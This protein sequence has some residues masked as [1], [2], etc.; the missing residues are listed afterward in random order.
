M[1]GRV[2]SRPGQGLRRSW[3]DNHTYKERSLGSQ[4]TQRFILHIPGYPTKVPCR[5]QRGGSKSLFEDSFQKQSHIAN[6][7]ANGISQ[8]G[9]AGLANANNR[10]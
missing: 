1:V 5:R 3:L 4:E 6:S 2:R 10:K 9:R 8:P 7:G